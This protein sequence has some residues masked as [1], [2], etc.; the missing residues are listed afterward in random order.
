[1]QATQQE[2]DL[3]DGFTFLSQEAHNAATLCKPFWNFSTL[4]HLRLRFFPLSTTVMAVSYL[5]TFVE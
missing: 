3:L 1:M 5:R 4:P 2:S